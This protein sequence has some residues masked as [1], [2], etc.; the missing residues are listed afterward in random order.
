[1][2][3][4]TFT[5]EDRIKFIKTE[6]FTN[7]IIKLLNTYTDDLELIKEY[8]RKLFLITQNQCIKKTSLRTDYSKV[9]IGNNRWETMPDKDIYPKIISDIANDFSK[10]LKEYCKKL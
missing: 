7:E 10:F 5:T 2:E 3:I 1:M 6:E 9:H 8:N 4:I